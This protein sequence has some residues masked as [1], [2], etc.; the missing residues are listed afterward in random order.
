MDLALYHPGHGYYASRARRSGRAGDFYTSVDV[1]PLFGELL[2]AQFAE[3]ARLLAGDFDLVEAA[4]GDGRL[5]RDVLDALAREA[6][7][8]YGRARVHLVE[9]SPEGRAAQRERLGPHAERLRTSATALPSPIHGVVF[10]NELLDALPAHLLVSRDEGPREIYVDVKGN[11]LVERES[12]VSSEALRR[13]AEADP[14][15]PSGLRFEVSLDAIDWVRRAGRALGRGFLLLIDYGDAARALRSASRP[16]GTLRA[17]N[18]HRVSAR[19]IDSPGEQDLTANVN[20][21]AIVRAASAASLE[22]LGEVEQT[23]FLLGLGALE[24]LERDEGALP[25]LAAIRRRLA[26]KS[27]LVPGGIGTT[28]R[29]LVFGKNTGRPPLAGLSFAR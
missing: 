19:W 21:T 28:H 18:A 8:E 16:D 13:E 22:H 9:R 4:A 20:F 7:E 1:G 29:V 23:R 17:F 12:D 5:M 24:R 14:L 26:A 15:P 2:A 25:P 27:L 6:V 11:R 3:M 10:A